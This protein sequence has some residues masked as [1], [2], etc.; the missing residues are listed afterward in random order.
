MTIDDQG[1]IEA[2]VE[3]LGCGLT[4]THNM[5]GCLN[6]DQNL[7]GKLT[8]IILT[9]GHTVLGLAQGARTDEGNLA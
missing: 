2:T 6:E 7:E 8:S 5:R 4:S 3:S 9:D 1:G